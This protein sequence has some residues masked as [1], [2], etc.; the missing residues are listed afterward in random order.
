MACTHRL[1]LLLALG[2]LIG[3]APALAAPISTDRPGNGNAATVVAPAV[4]QIETSALYAHTGDGDAHAVTFPTGLRY[5]IVPRLEARVLTSILGV[6]ADPAETQVQPTDTALGLKLGVIQQRDYGADMAVMVDVFF[7]SGE[8]PFT[9]DV[10]VP[11]LRGALARSL[12]NGLGVLAN[13]GFDV[14][15]D[16]AG[17]YAR[18]LYV[19]QINYAPPIEGRPLTFFVETFGKTSFGNRTDFTQIDAGVLWLLTPDFQL[20][21][22]T[23]HGLDG[24]APDFQIAIGLSARV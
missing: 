2:L 1:R 22:F 16:E 7:P 8:P 19:G 14:P 12:P 23:Q 20:D 5:G 6:Q 17:R 13:F 24:A 15:E 18:L 10:I 11:E 21:L 3:S 9:A 4:L